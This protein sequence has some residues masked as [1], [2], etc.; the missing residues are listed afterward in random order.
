[1]K[2]RGYTEHHSLNQHTDRSNERLHR[3][4]IAESQERLHRTSLT[5]GAGKFDCTK[6][7]HKMHNKSSGYMW[8]HRASPMII[9]RGEDPIGRS[10]SA[11]GRTTLP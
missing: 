3:T 2:S 5:E 8:L 9:A 1:M 4:S 7:A 6:D 10:K 11:K